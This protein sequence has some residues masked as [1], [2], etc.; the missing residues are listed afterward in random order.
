MPSLKSETWAST[1]Q[2]L[3]D[4]VGERR[5][6]LWF[7]NI[8]PL[9]VEGDTVILGVPNLFVR[10][11]LETHFLDLLRHA[12]S[13]KPGKLPEVRFAIEPE[14]FQ[15]SRAR[16]LEASAEVVAE[17]ASQWKADGRRQA[18]HIRPDFTLDNFVVGPSNKLAHACAL[19]ILE[20]SSNRLHP[21]FVHSRCGLGKTHL[22]QAIWHEAQKRNDGRKVEYVS[23]ESFTNQFIYAMRSRRLDA[24]RHRYR[25]ADILLVDDVHFLRN[26]TGF[27][28]ELLH[29]YDAVDVRNRQLVLASDV[30]PKML[31]RIRQN[32]VSRFASGMVVRIGQ[33]DFS[34]R[35]AILKAKL[36]QLG[37]RVPDQVVRYIARGFEGNVRELSGAITVVLAYA[38][39]TGHRIDIALART[40]LA[41][42]TRP[43]KGISR[44]DSVEKVVA[45]RYSVR[46]AD[47]RA[48]RMTRA[49]RLARQMC[50]YLARRCT[51]M[52]CRE[53]A[54]H[55]GSEH[56]SMVVLASKRIEEAI[57]KDANFAELAPALVEEIKRR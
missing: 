56:H 10:E 8:R 23:A 42:L 13:R 12:L 32:L 16:Q 43:E 44:M 31:T 21:L 39:L 36:Y 51:A 46:P 1:L 17:G 25:G 55:F 47:L 9:R 24:F 38:G 41:G 22:L 53:I 20:S 52:S 2:S 49:T 34:T 19:E 50:M 14:L 57:G 18:T 33:P 15:K 11:W 45:H 35:V 4:K 40:A 5:F 27:Q 3:K 30:H 26:K 29:T 54:Q 28:E 48:K 6:A 37:R 7:R